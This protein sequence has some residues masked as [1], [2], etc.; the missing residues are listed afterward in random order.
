M[1]KTNIINGLLQSDM[2]GGGYHV[3]NLAN[4]VNAGD[5]V[6]KGYVDGFGL[7]GVPPTG[8]VSF[9]NQ[10]IINLGAPTSSTDAA[11]KAY[12]DAAPA[13]MKMVVLLSSGT[14]TLDANVKALYVIGVGGGGAGGGV[15]A[16]SGAVSTVGGGGGGGA[17]SSLFQL[18]PAKTSYVYVIGAGGVGGSNAA[19]GV[20]G[21][22]SFDSPAVLL[23]K[24]GQGGGVGA[25]GISGMGA[26]SSGGN[27][28]SQLSGLG[29]MTIDGNWGLGGLVLN[30]AVGLMTGSVG[31][32]SLLSGEV[33][34]T[35]G[36]GNGLPG[37]N[38]GG[39][40]AGAVGINSGA[41]SG[42]GGAGGVII[43]WEIF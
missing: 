24:G 29:T 18:P 7:V 25:A 33:V 13:S 5:A 11:T 8:P 12:V 15:P 43:V 27:G 3:I 32:S 37:R 39:A 4:P 22:T 2:D 38:Y 16:T 41:A 10:R 36:V 6:N 23:A 14:F 34:P 30:G 19:G 40:G 28:G 1:G 21:D 17:Y 9:N 35:T 26:S 31:G 20:G 42:G